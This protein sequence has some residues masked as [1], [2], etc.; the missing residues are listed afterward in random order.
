MRTRSSG[1]VVEPSTTPRRRRNKKR[2]QQQVDPTIVEEK[3]VVTMADTR[4][5]AELL[6]APT[7]GNAEAIVVPPIPA[8]HFELNIITSMMKYK[9]EPD[10]AIKL[11]LFPFSIDGPA[12]IWLEKEPPRSITTW[13]DLDRF[14]D[15]LRAWPHHGF[16]ELHQLD[17]F[18]NSLNLTDQDFL[19]SAADGNLL[20]KSTPDALKII[21]KKSKVRTSRNKL[22]VSK[23]PVTNGN[24]FPGYQNNIQAYVSAAAVNY[25]QGNAGHH[26]PS[27]AHQVQPPGFPPVHNNQNR[28]NNY[29]P[30]NSTYRASIPPT[31]AAP[32]NELTNYMKINETNMQAMRNQIT[33]MK[34]E[35]KNKFQA[36]IL[37]FN[38]SFLDA[39]LYMPKFAST[40][41]NLLSNKE[42]L[43][44][45]ANTPVNENCSAVILKKLP[46]KLGDLGK[47]LIP[48]NFP[49][50]AECLALADLGAS[51]N[52]MPLSIWKKLSL[53]ELTPTQM[54][55]ELADQ[56]TTRPTGIA[57]DVFV[58]DARALNDVYGEELTLRVGDEA[59]TFKVGNTSKFSYNDAE[60][61]NRIDVIDVAC[62]EYSQEVLGFSGNSESG[63]PTLISEPIIAKS[64]PSLTL[65]EGGDFILEEIEGYLAS[66]SVPPGI[67][68]EDI[69]EFFST[70]PIPVEDSDFFLEK[71]E[72]FPSELET[73]RFDIKEKN[74][75]STTDHADV[76]LPEYERFYSEGD[77]RLLEKFL[78]NDPSSPLLPKEI[79]AVELKNEKS[80]VDEPPELELK[81]LPS[82]LEYAFLEGTDKLPVI[83]SKNMKDEDKERL[84]KVLKSHKQAISWKLS[85]IKVL[86]KTIVYT[87][88]SALKYL[89]AKKDSKPRLLRWILLL[90]EFDVEIH[91]KKGAENLAA[92]HL[93][94]LENPQSDPEKKEIIETFPLE[95]LG[96]VNFHGDSNTPW[97]YA[98]QVIRRC[99]YGQEAVDI[100]TTYH[101]RPTGGHHGANYTAKKVFDSGFYW[102]TIYQDA[103]DLVTQCDACQCQGKISQRDEMPQNA[104][105]VCKIFDIWGIDFMGPFPSSRGNK[106]IL[107][108]VDYLSKWVE[109][110]ALPTN[111]ARVVCNFLKSLFAPFGT[112]RAIISDRDT[113]FC[114]DQFAKHCNFDL[115]TA[116]DHQ[117]VQMNVLNELYDQAYENSLIYKEKTKKIHDSKIKN[118]IFNVGLKCSTSNCGSKPIGKKKNDRILQTSSRNMKNKVEV[119]PRKVNKKNRII[120]PICDADVKHSLLNANSEL[121]FATC[122]KCMFDGIHDTC[123]LD[124]V[125]NVNSH[126]KY[127]KKH[128][129]KIFENLRVIQ[130][131]LWYLNSRCSNHMTWN[132]SQ[133][134]N[135]VSKFLE[136]VRFGNDQIARIIGYGDHQLGNVT[137]SRVYYVEGLGHN[138]FSVG[139]FCDTDLEVAFRKN[140]YFIQNLEGVDLLLGSRDTNLYIISLDDMLKTSLICL[141]SK[142]SNTKSWLWHRRLSHLNFACALGKRKKSSQQPKAED[143]NQEKLYLLHMDLCGPMRVASINEKRTKDEAP[144]AIIKCIKNIQVLLNATVRNVRTD[145]E[146]EFI[147]QTLCEFYENVSI[148]HQTSVAR[149]PQQNDVVE[150]QNWTLVETAR[151]MLIFSKAILF[152]YEAKRRYSRAK[153]KTFEENTY[154]TPYAVSNKEDTVLNNVSVLQND[155][156]YSVNT[157]RRTAIQQTH[158]EWCMIR[159]STKELLTPFENPK[160]VL[161]SRR[162][163]FETP[164]LVES[165]SPEFDQISKVE[166]HIEEEVTEIMVEAMEQYMSKTR[167]EYRSGI[168]R[169]TI[170]VDTQFEQ[171]G[172]KELLMKYPQH[173][174][175]DM[176][177][178][179]LFYN[180][181]DVPTRQILDS[182]GAIPTKTA[183][184]AKVSIQ[185]MAEYS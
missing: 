101:N 43:F 126:A 48:C 56:S 18:Y 179:I 125:K 57:E 35:L 95:T 129:N 167:G 174:L 19:N 86:S 73:F 66:D 6:R 180:G 155:S 113:H 158:T 13:D 120:E 42:K 128:K 49:E 122:N 59:I 33:N 152:L 32:S 1:P 116:G 14:K 132:R 139:Q 146:T 109:A 36:T 47:F 93:S 140:T 69:S 100:L 134:M 151:I 7:E 171:K 96:M 119:Q 94:R 64:S 29:N 90:Q 60:S 103:H 102:P 41:K 159:S 170:D 24:A 105:Q 142:A 58:R 147:N 98:D 38:L 81:D 111:D 91:D 77:I 46:E 80:S 62:E 85:D 70:F 75:G 53:P 123:L 52:L 114:N 106:Y 10:S 177:E 9:D 124:F 148:S 175:T 3:P 138:L 39:L 51:I 160:R 44:E 31:Q 8:E 110:K 127:A 61:I 84:I 65:F 153:T 20:E 181:L 2:S 185:E 74:S 161:L 82:H 176:Q 117:K 112:P 34:A 27:V 137:I 83:I 144:E 21:D 121:V 150:R 89:L 23:C 45:V 71:P 135:F 11:M 107:V 4:T 104:I 163:L 156:A 115:K 17:T 88:H 168:A 26:P 173:Y 37:Q 50:I 5:M 79:K 40:F 76:S 67:D 130:I 15:L 118:H 182:K 141:L 162:K 178:V 68:S 145:N 183:V 184:D 133:L 143:N 131:V 92:D 22:V 78:N 157:I 169:P 55:L 108:A 164:S 166:E 154:L 99:V 28:G 16:T 149:T 172:F 72:T 87:D 165:N 25:N 12:R 30:G 54:I 136:T 97:I 63:N